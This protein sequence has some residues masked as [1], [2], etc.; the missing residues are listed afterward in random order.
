MQPNTGPRTWA[1]EQLASLSERFPEWDF[2]YVPTYMGPSSGTWCAR[3]SGAMIATCNA[4][5]PDDMAEAITE[6]QVGIADHIQ[7]ART[8]LESPRLGDGRRN[9]LEQLLAALTRLQGI[10]A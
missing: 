7:A 9:V 6:F 2:W 8:E 4:S 10:T 1:D 3:P 5:T